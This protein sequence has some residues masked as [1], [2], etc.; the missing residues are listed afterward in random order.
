MGGSSSRGGECKGMGGSS[1]R[2]G[3]CKGMG[4]SSSS[5]KLARPAGQCCSGWH[6]DAFEMAQGGWRLEVQEV[7]QGQQENMQPGAGITIGNVSRTQLMGASC[8]L[9]TK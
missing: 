9:S 6:E 4:G 8:Q 2:G 5:S 3:E 1:S 7:K